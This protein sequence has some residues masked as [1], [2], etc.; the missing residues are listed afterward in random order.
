MLQLEKSLQGEKFIAKEM[1]KYLPNKT[2]K[3]IRERRRHIGNVFK[4]CVIRK[5]VRKEEV[6]LP[7]HL[8]R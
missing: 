4:K 3:Q 5:G 7:P 1:S 8:G 6:A 2:N